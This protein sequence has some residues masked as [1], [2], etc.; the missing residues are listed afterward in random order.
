MA[1]ALYIV[2]RD[3][4]D[5]YVRLL[6]LEESGV[7]FKQRDTLKISMGARTP[8]YATSERRRGGAVQVSESRELGSVGATFMAKGS[9]TDAAITKLEALL[10][11]ADAAAER[12]LWWQPDGSTDV[13]LYPL[14]GPAQVSVNYT[15][16][17]LMSGFFPVEV[18]WPAQPWVEGLVQDV[19]DDFRA[20]DVG[21]A[22][23]ALTAAQ[24]FAQDY[25]TT[26]TA[27]TVATGA[28]E[29]P[30]QNLTN[31]ARVARLDREPFQDGWVTVKGKAKTGAAATAFAV[32]PGLRY[33]TVSGG[34]FFAALNGG[35]LVVYEWNGSLN[36]RATV[37]QAAPAAGTS[38]WLRIR[39]EGTSVTAEYWTV[40]PTPT[41]APTTTTT[42]TNAATLR[43][44]YPLLTSYG[45]TSGA[46]NI[47]I[48]EEFEVRPYSWRLQNT[49][50]TINVE[51]L[52]G[53]MDAATDVD[54]TPAFSD[55]D[56]P[57]HVLLGWRR[58]LTGRA[59]ALSGGGATATSLLV[60]GETFANAG[61]STT[62]VLATDATRYRGG[63]NQAM[64]IPV[65]ATAGLTSIVAVI[66]PTLYEADD[67]SDTVTCAVV[68]RY[69]R[70]SGIISPRLAVGTLTPGGS[71]TGYSPEFGST[72]RLLPGATATARVTSTTLGTVTL[73]RQPQ[74]AHLLMSLSWAAGSTAAQVLGIDE[75]YLVPVASLA[76]SPT[77]KG[78]DDGAYPTFTPALFS[79]TFTTRV[80]SY[81]TG[82]RRF[83]A[84][85][86][87][88]NKMF[89]TAALGMGGAD[90]NLPV[91]SEGVELL[92]RPSASVPDDPVYLTT[93]DI[94][95]HNV[96]V[97]LRVTPRYRFAA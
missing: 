32:T 93:A 48:V 44:G 14:V 68:A 40:R 18:T 2:S 34:Y 24:Q 59:P 52:P 85:V 27:T 13:S 36:S 81:G 82:L 12:W 22:G 76:M 21:T 39:G 77:D 63:S 30:V 73:R 72:G 88:S 89:D 43:T 11:Q 29:L 15:W 9:T 70:Q 74:V 97:H 26:V 50:G 69:Y 4:Q 38:Y 47:S 96:S 33:D 23:V 91:A 57:R 86:D 10:A 78:R 90:L 60:P 51:Q 54:L 55:T 62:A 84:G 94:L 28:L 53:T 16:P 25:T 1:D 92:V 42:Y 45:M 83:D 46:S 20:R 56:Y 95:T 17:V 80:R 87:G 79:G 7:I 3:E 66:D 35:N 41:G 64:T 65:L 61:G 37:A 19:S 5:Q 58:R 31:T 49:P 75:V 8:V 67:F 71:V 6:N